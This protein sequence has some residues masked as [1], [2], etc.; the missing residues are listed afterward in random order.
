MKHASKELSSGVIINKYE[1]TWLWQKRLRFDSLEDVL[2]KSQE[3][4]EK[5]LIKLRD[6]QGWAVPSS[7]QL[8]LVTTSLDLGANLLGLLFRPAV[9]GA[10]SLGELQ[11]RI[12]PP[13][14]H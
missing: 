2:R 10:W 4:S 7:A 14:Y 11:L 13:T 1:I 9:P 8:K 3:N 6:K 5:G 12:F